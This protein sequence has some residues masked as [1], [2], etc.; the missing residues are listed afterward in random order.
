MS[1]SPSQNP[2][3]V[4]IELPSSNLN[5]GRKVNGTIASTTGKCLMISSAEEIAPSGAIR[6]QGKDLLFVGEILQCTLG[7]D[8]KWSVQMTVKSKLMIF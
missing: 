8:G 1:R 4:V 5:P 2:E 6:V 3:S 7:T